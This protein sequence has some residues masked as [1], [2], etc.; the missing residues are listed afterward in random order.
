MKLNDKIKLIRE[1]LS[2]EIKPL[3]TRSILANAQIEPKIEYPKRN[4]F[5]NIRFQTALT[6]LLII[7]I[8]IP[9]AIFQTTDD[10]ENDLVPDE[11]QV[12]E[13]I[14]EV[15]AF[16][17]TSAV[18]LVYSSE[19]IFAADITVMQSDN[20]LVYEELS[21]L[22]RL[23]APIEM[24]LS[25]NSNF[26]SLKSDKPYYT[27]KIEYIG[28]GLLDEALHYLIYFN[29]RLTSGTTTEIECI[30]VMGDKTINLSG[31]TNYIQN[32]TILKMNYF[33]NSNDFKNYIQVSKNLSHPFDSYD[34]MI[35]QNDLVISKNKLTFNENAQKYAVLENT[36]SEDQSTIFKIY[37]SA[38]HSF[39]IE[40]TISSPEVTEEHDTN[41]SVYQES[42]QIDVII[43]Q[44]NSSYHV[45]TSD[46][47][48]LITF[49]KKK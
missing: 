40:Y 47:H 43:D 8:L 3:D 48:G 49:E 5:F 28:Q 29:E 21:N 34:Y 20:L 35:V 44:D 16:V 32:N 25:Y 42:G 17:A 19:D 24:M 27:N 9:L 1:E 46:A 10:S 23:L 30:V 22:N 45:Y 37:Q 7:G 26:T 12:Y 15:Y 41:D 18:A 14:D 39:T 11:G 36:I 33:V 6:T 31:E 38:T 4:R 13:T 2:N